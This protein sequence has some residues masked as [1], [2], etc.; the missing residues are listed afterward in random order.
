M[1]FD[2]A[3]KTVWVA[4]ETGL[5]GSALTRALSVMPVR[6]LSAPH[7]ALDLTRQSDTEDWIAEKRPDVIIMAA[8][9]VG[10]IGAN[11]AAPADFIRDNLAMAQNVIHGAYRAGV[12]KL[13]YLGSSCIY[14]KFAAQPI[15]ESALMTGALEETNQWYA[16]AKIAGLKMCAAYRRQY[17]CDF[18][19][20]MPT[21][22]Y[23]PYDRF[24]ENASHVIP[25]MMMKMHRAKGR[26]DAA[27]TFWGTGAP[28]REF[29]YVDDLASALIHLL[30]HYSAEQTVNVGSGD[31][32]SM[33][34]LAAL[35][36]DTTG[37]RGDIVWDTARP[38]GTPRKALDSS[39]LR[40]LGWRPAMPLGAGLVRTYDWYCRS[41]ESLQ[42]AA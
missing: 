17:G 24:D 14:P 36:K 13:L 22:L 19:S 28:L 21:N 38:D 30:T 15:T 23:G 33:T 9:R 18:I 4:G 40:G 32:I 35:M 8:G 1:T 10:G 26:G 25:A 31:E 11:A 16:V 6:I 12:Q 37:F 39:T 3:H 7:A 34:D 29:L 20:A 42:N 27:V 5:V 41:R 2:L